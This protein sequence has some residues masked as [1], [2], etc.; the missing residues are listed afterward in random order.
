ML[1]VIVC[2]G[3]DFSDKHFLFSK[4]DEFHQNN[5]ITTIIEGG[6]NGA[7]FLAKCW[8]NTNGIECI[9][10]QADWKTHGK[11]AGPIRNSEMLKLNPDVVIAFHG[12]A[13]TNNMLM[14]AKQ[15]GIKSIIFI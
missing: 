3:R 4:L 15:N 9:T 2:G 11:A 6:A 7:D 10:V 5:N 12:G 1:R 14:Q 13:G 8:A